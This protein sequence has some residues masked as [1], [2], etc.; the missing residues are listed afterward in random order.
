MIILNELDSTCGIS[1]EE[2]RKQRQFSALAEEQKLVLNYIKENT[3][4]LFEVANSMAENAHIINNVRESIL[5]DVGKI[6]QKPLKHY[7]WVPG[8]CTWDYSGEIEENGIIP[9]NITLEDFLENEYTGNSTA[10]FI[11]RYGLAYEQ[12]GEYFANEMVGYFMN[13]ISSYMRDYINGMCGT[14]LTEK[15]FNEIDNINY[16]FTSIYED[17]D[18]MLDCCVIF[19]D[20]DFK[21]TLQEILDNYK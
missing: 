12:Y 2:L 7:E 19:T 17:V 15:E 20:K 1:D 16:D 5:S 14:N 18:I 6:L 21:M 3:D 8:D 11:S 4:E 10:T 13:E 9:L